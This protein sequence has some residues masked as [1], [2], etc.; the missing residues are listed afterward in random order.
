[1]YIEHAP[2][3]V[4]FGALLVVY[5]FS[6]PLAIIAWYWR[7]YNYIRKGRFM[8]R[9]LF[10][11]LLIGVLLTSLASYKM[12]SIYFYI[13]SPADGETCMSPSCIS[14]SPL[15]KEYHVEASSLK[16]LGV[17]SAG[18]MTLYWVYDTGINTTLELPTL[19]KYVVVVRPLL[20]VP[21]TEVSV[22][23][24][25][26]G[27]AVL[28]KKFYVTWPFMPGGVL[29]RE[30]GVRFTVLMPPGKGGPGV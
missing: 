25:S 19:M 14:S 20:L 7:S 6:I 12:V 4:T 29:T 3:P 10:L 28:R 8:L 5:Y 21:S 26:G 22:Y 30:L 27:R 9:R 24:V 16:S 15:L 13:H 23:Y 1:M 18:P 11:Y 2:S 17:P